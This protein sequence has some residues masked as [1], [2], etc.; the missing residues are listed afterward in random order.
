MAFSVPPVM[1]E[2]TTTVPLKDWWDYTDQEKQFLRDRWTDQ[3]IEAVVTWLKEE[4][5]LPEL[6]V[7]HLP[8]FIDQLRDTTRFLIINYCIDL[9]GIDL[10]SVKLPLVHF[11][12]ACLQ[13]A[14]LA[15]AGLD[16][17]NLE[18][19]NLQVTD[20]SFAELQGADLR[21]ANLQGA[22]LYFA[23]LQGADL[24]RTNLQGANLRYAV[25][26]NTI[27]YRPSLDS[28]V[29][30]RDIEWRNCYVGD[31]LPTYRDLKRI[32]RNAG[33]DELVTKFH[34][35]DNW[36]KTRKLSV[37]EAI[38]RFLFLEWTYG[39]GSRPWWLLWYSLG[40]IFL[41]SIIFFLPTLFPR[42]NLGIYTSK[43]GSA[44]KRRLTWRQ[45][46]ECLYFSLLAFATF[47]YGAMRPKQWL[48]LFRLKLVEHEPV[49]W[50]RIFVGIEA[51]LGIWV[52]ALLVTVLFGR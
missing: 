31:D 28:T 44:R 18:K 10:G 27:L 5:P 46:H 37:F 2:N 26:K 8:D 23:N 32:Y 42:A 25:F 22:D 41:F 38:P 35:W 6:N 40:V 12:G 13:G 20:L 50:I 43:P 17:S 49:G 7:G 1:A 14:W 39:Y 9:R 16:S 15:T 24:R 30:Y 29:S 51:A 52:L 48:Q 36:V 34:Y 3:K 11:G 33:M 4:R 47:G 19:A 45:P 21:R